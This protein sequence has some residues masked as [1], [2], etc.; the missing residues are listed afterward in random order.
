MKHVAALVILFAGF[1][2]L[3]RGNTDYG[4]YGYD[5]AD[6]MFAASR[7]VSAN[8]FDSPTLPLPQFLQMG[9]HRGSRSEMSEAIRSANDMVFYRHWH[10]PLYIDWLEVTSRFASSEPAMRAW[11]YVF[12]VLAGVWI[13]FAAGF[14]GAALFLWSYPVVASTELAPH[15]LFALCSLATL[16]LLAKV[17]ET[18]E[19]RFWYGAVF[20]TALAF[21]TLEVAFV[22]ILTVMVCGHLVRDRLHP[23]LGLAA[24]SI[25]LFVGTVLVIWP[26]AW[27]K[28]SFVKAYLFMAYLAVFRKGAWGPNITL[29]D[30]WWGRFSTSPVQWIVLAVA[31]GL[32]IYQLA[33]VGN[34]RAG[35]HPALPFALFAVLMIAATFRVNSQFPRY[36]LTFFPAVVVI[37]A[38]LL[39]EYNRRSLVV[40]AIA[41]AAFVTA[42]LEIV[43]RRQ[44]HDPALYAL[45]NLIR[46][47]HLGDK[48]LLVPQGAIPQ[49]HYYFPA[50]TLKGYPDE[51]AIPNDLKQMGV[52]AVIYGGNPVRYRLGG[53][54]H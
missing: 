42:Y 16:F 34:R 47:N 6:Y 49:I 44:A 41:A 18:G 9:L 51:T 45:V 43:P 3:A 8:L 52:D 31:A 19:R 28:L 53:V 48:H 35:Y 11:T 21:C 13:Y 24:K 20:T 36:T 33:P 46:D 54:A 1:F 7:G 32:M 17:M 27:L 10:G 4:P 15:Q 37:T 29:W 26:A 14:L 50:T 40:G 22:V 38:I 30:T 12:P 25:G 23:D 39:K 2:V 5:E